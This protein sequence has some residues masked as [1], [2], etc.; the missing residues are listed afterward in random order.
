MLTLHKCH[1]GDSQASSEASILL[2][3]QDQ[4]ITDRLGVT[5]KSQGLVKDRKQSEGLGSD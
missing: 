1:F 3:L 5:N 2:H 4:R